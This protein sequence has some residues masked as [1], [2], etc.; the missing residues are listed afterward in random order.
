MEDSCWTGGTRGCQDH[1]QQSCGVLPYKCGGTSPTWTFGNWTECLRVQHNIWTYAMNFLTNSLSSLALAGT[2]P[3]RDV[4]ER[5]SCPEQSSR[6]YPHWSP[7]LDHCCEAGGG[8][9]EHSDGRKDH[10]PSHHFSACQWCGDQQRT[11]DTGLFLGLSDF[12]EMTENI[13][14]DQIACVSGSHFELWCALNLHS[15]WRPTDGDSWELKKS[16]RV[17]MEKM[18]FLAFKF[19]I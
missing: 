13:K 8:Q 17:K 12:F 3:V 7:H 5:S 4:W 11:V 6:E 14:G 10:W 15:I 2:G 16:Q 9:W 1:A 19:S 18:S